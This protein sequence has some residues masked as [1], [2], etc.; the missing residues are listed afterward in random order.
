[1]PS[2]V[3]VSGD[4]PDDVL[5]NTN[6]GREFSI[7]PVDGGDKGEEF[8]AFLALDGAIRGWDISA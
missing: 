1:M 7:G 3:Q 4:F 2:N 6:A 5:P 8:L